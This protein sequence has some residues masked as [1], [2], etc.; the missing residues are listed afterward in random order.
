MHRVRVRR[1]DHSL[2]HVDRAGAMSPNT[3]PS[4]ATTTAARTFSRPIVACAVAAEAADSVCIGFLLARIARRA[5]GL[6]YCRAA[7]RR[8]GRCRP[9]PGRRAVPWSLY[10]RAWACGGRFADQLVRGVAAVEG[11]ARAMPAVAPRQRQL[12]GDLGSAVTRAVEE[13]AAADGF[14]AV[15]EAEQAASAGEVRRRRCRRRARRC[16]ECRRHYPTST[17]T[18]E[19]LACFAALVSVSATT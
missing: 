17:V 12:R 1:V 16:A 13:E 15:L 3:T 7:C 19:A 9:R 4:A 6:I 11:A 8:Q 2:N 14:H 18:A 10:L 5:G